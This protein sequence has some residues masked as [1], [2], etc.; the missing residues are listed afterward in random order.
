[1]WMWACGVLCGWV[2]VRARVF[3]V[4][5]FAEHPRRAPCG[6]YDVCAVCCVC[7][8]THHTNR[9]TVQMS[10]CSC[11]KEAAPPPEE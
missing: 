5:V 6:A 8:R 10:P 11:K 1:M 4:F 3:G 7:A 2:R 9:N